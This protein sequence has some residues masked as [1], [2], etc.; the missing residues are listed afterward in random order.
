M[1]EIKV[2]QKIKYGDLIYIE[3]TY[4]KSRTRNILTG[5][6][7]TLK[8]KLD[9]EIKKLDLSK[10]SIYLKDFEDHLFLIFPKM[11]DEFMNNKTFLNDGISLLKT[12]MKT[13]KSLAFDSDFKNNITKV[14]KAFQE[15]K[16]I[17]YSENEKFV[18]FM[19]KQKPIN[20]E[21]DFI[22]IHFKTQSFVKRNENNSIKSSALVLTQTYSEDCIFF[23]S[24][25]SSFNLNMKYVFSNQNVFICKRE[26]NFWSNSHYLIV[27]PISTEKTN[28]NSAKNNNE[29]GKNDYNDKYDKI[30]EK[31]Q[32]YSNFILDFNEGQGQPF[33]IKVCSDYID[34]SSSNLSFAMPVWLV[35]Q[36]A[37]RYLNIKTIVKADNTSTE[38]EPI[39]Q[40][41]EKVSF[42]VNNN[43][44]A[45]VTDGINRI[46]TL[47]SEGK[48]S[49]KARSNNP[50]NN[51]P[52]ILNNNINNINNE[53]QTINNIEHPKR[54]VSMLNSDR[55]LRNLNQQTTFNQPLKKY[56]ITFE[57]VDKEKSINNINGLFYIEQYNEQE[58]Q[59]KSVSDKYIKENFQLKLELKMPSFVEFHKT[60]RFRHITSK[61]YLGIEETNEDIKR[62]LTGNAGEQNLQDNNDKKNDYQGKTKAKLILMDVP[63]DNCNWMLM[64]SYKI[65]ETNDYLLSKDKG[66]K[67]TENSNVAEEKEEEEEEEEK[68]ENEEK[69]NPDE[70]DKIENKSTTSE[71]N[72][73]NDITHKIKIKNNEILRIFHIKTKKFLCF[74]E[75]NNRLGENNRSSQTNPVDDLYT[76]RQDRKVVVPNLTLSRVPY[77]SDLVKLMPSET[78]QSLEISI[79]LYFCHN[80]TEQIDYIMKKDYKKLLGVEAHNIRTTIEPINNNITS[81]NNYIINNNNQFTQENTAK[82]EFNNRTNISLNNINNPGSFNNNNIES[83]NY[84]RTQDYKSK[85]TIATDLKALR[86]KVKE[87]I[88]TYQN[89]IAYCLNNFPVKYDINISPGKPLYYRQQ[90]LFEQGLFKKT[91]KYLEYTK[92][93]SKVFENYTDM[94]KKKFEEEEETEKLR[95]TVNIDIKKTIHKSVKTME[96]E[97]FYDKNNNPN[98]L[99]LDVCKN[100]RTT[101]KLG[102]DFIYSM[103]K[104]NPTNKEY[105]FNHKTLFVHYFLAYEEAAKCFMDLLKENDNFMNLINNHEEKDE[106]KNEEKSEDKNED[107]NED[108]SEDIDKKT[109]EDNIIDTIL[110]YLNEF[111]N[112]EI[113]NLSLLSKFL[114]IGDSGITSNQQYIFEELFFHGKDR[115]LIKIKPIYNDIEF[116]VVYKEDDN[117]QECNLIEFCNNR[118]LVERGMIKYLAEQLN[119]YANL[120]YGRNYVC[121]E[122]IRK[123][124]PLDHLIFHI[125]KVDLN[126]EILAGLINILNYVYIDIEPHIMNVYPTLIKRVSPNLRIERFGKEKIKTYIPLN[127]LSLILCISLFYLNNI[128]YGIVL[129]NT[130]NINMIYNIIKFHLYENVVYSPMDIEEVINNN[131]DQRLHNLKDEVKYNVIN[132]EEYLINKKSEKNIN[133]KDDKR[134]NDLIDE[135]PDLLSANEEEHKLLNEMPT[136]DEENKKGFIG[137]INSFYNKYGFKFLEYNFDAPIGE[138]YVLFV[139]DRIN[140]FFLNS[141]ILSNIDN[142]TEDK[143]IISQN[144][145]SVSSNDILTQSNINYLMTALIEIKKILTN[146]KNELNI[147][148]ISIMKYIEKVINYI[149]DIKTEDMIAYLL[150]NLLK[151]NYQLIDEIIKDKENV[152]NNFEYLYP[153]LKEKLFNLPNIKDILMDNEYYYYQLFNKINFY[154]NIP[155][156][157]MKPENS[158]ENEILNA[159]L[160]KDKAEEQNKR[161]LNNSLISEESSLI[162]FN[163]E[164]FKEIQGL[165]NNYFSSNSNYVNE[166]YHDSEYYYNQEMPFLD[167]N[168]EIFFMNSVI[169]KNLLELIIRILEMNVNAKM[170]KIL[171]RI[172]K[173]LISQRKELFICAKNIL[174]LYRNNDLQKYYL[175]SLT[176][177]ELSLLAEKTEKWMTEDHVPLVIK[178]MDKPENISL[179]EIE[180]DKRDF[181][182]VYSTIYKYLSMIIDFESNSYYNEQEVKLIQ[183]IFY[184]FQMENILS[185]LMKEII[186][187]Y[188]AGENLEEKIEKEKVKTQEI[189]KSQ[190]ASINKNYLVTSL[191]SRRSIR[192]FLEKQKSKK[193]N[194]NSK[195]NKTEK[196]LVYKIALEKLIKIIFKLF[197]ALI[198]NTSPNINPQI[199]ELV[200]F[201]KEYKYLLEFGLLPLIVELSCDD[202]FVHHDIQYLIGL[203]NEQLNVINIKG[204]NEHFN[205]YS[206]YFQKE[207]SKISYSIKDNDNNNTV[208]TSKTFPSKLNFQKLLKKYSLWLKLMKNIIM[209]T[210]EERY[211]NILLEKYVE[212]ITVFD[213]FSLVTP[214][215]LYKNINF[216]PSVLINDSVIAN[217]GR[218]NAFPSKTIR[219]NTLDL[220]SNSTVN[221]DVNC[222]IEYYRLVFIYYMIKIT[223][224]LIK[225]NQQ[226]KQYISGLISIKKLIKFI[227]ELEPPFSRNQ[228]TSLIEAKNYRDSKMFFKLQYYFKVKYIGC[229]LILSISKNSK[230]NRKYMAKNIETYYKRLSEDLKYTFNFSSQIENF[231]KLTQKLANY[232]LVY[233]KYRKCMYKYFFKGLFPLIYYHLSIFNDKLF[234]N[235]NDYQ[236]AKEQ[237]MKINKKWSRLYLEFNNEHDKKPFKSLI[238]YMEHKKKEYQNVFNL[239]NSAS[240]Y[241]ISFAETRTITY[242]KTLKQNFVGPDETKLLT[243]FGDPNRHD[244]ILLEITINTVN[245]LINEI[246]NNEVI[247]KCIRREKKRMARN[248]KTKINFH[249]ILKKFVEKGAQ[250]QTE[251]RLKNE[252]EIHLVNVFLKFIQENADNKKY[253]PIIRELIE[254]M[255]YLVLVTPEIIKREYK[256]EKNNLNYFDQKVLEFKE[257]FFYECQKSY[258]NN[259]AIEIFLKIASQGGKYCHND[260]FNMIIYFYKAILDGGN[261]DVQKKFIQ[262]FQF[263]PNN[264]N[265]FRYISQSFN[266]DVLY[267]LNADPFVEEINI[268]NQNLE[269]VTDKLRFLQ[270]L[271]ENHNQILQNYLREQTNNRISYNFLNILT[272]YLSMLL[273]KLGDLIEKYKKIKRYCIELYYKR[274]LFLLDTI[275]EFLQGPCKNNQEYLI[276]TKVVELFNKIMEETCIITHDDDEEL[277]NNENDEENIFYLSN[278]KANPDSFFSENITNTSRLGLGTEENLYYSD[279]NVQKFKIFSALSDYEKSML[280]FKISLVLLSIIEGRHK[281][282]SVIRKVLRD[283]NYRLVFEKCGEIYKKLRNEMYFFLFIDDNV[284]DIEDLDDKLVAEA[285]FNLYFLMETLVSMENEETELKIN[286]TQIIKAIKRNDK[287][288]KEKLQET[289]TNVDTILKAFEFYSENSL[290][291]E[292]L[293][294]NEIFKVYCPRLQFFNGFDEKMKKDLND[295]ADRTSLQTKLTYLMNKK[296][297]IYMTLKQINILERKYGKFKPLKFLLIYQDKIQLVGLILVI[298]MNIL[299]FIG[300]SAEKDK[301]QINVIQNARIFGL[302]ERTSKA[303]LHFF[304]VII[305]VFDILIFLEF[306]TKDAILIYKNLHRKFLKKSFENK[307]GYIRDFEIHRVYKFLKSS[308]CSLY[309]NKFVIYLKLVINLHVI[310]AISYMIFAILGIFVHHFFFAFHL[311]EFIKSQPILN[312]VFLAFYEPLAE[313]VY[314]YIFFFILIYFYSLLIFYRY[315]DLMPDLSCES[316]LICMMYIYSNTF[317]SGGNLGNFIDTKEESINLSGNMERY[318]LDISYTFIMV[319]LVWQM[320]CGLILDAFDSLRGDREEI[321]EDMETNCYICGLKRDKIEKYYVGKE[322][323]DNHLQ[324]HSVENYLFYM[325]Y[326]EDKDPNEYSGLESYVKENV[327]IESIDWFPRERCLKIEEWENKHKS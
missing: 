182:L 66:I 59:I 117:F 236:R 214:E 242:V 281:K 33:Q 221:T 255:S 189:R 150:E 12:K 167:V 83:L 308:G 42:N 200:I 288:Q 206:S 250:T 265:F 232:F 196:Q 292:I 174:L 152:G 287:M 180:Y 155:K 101:I 98:S 20:Y 46:N 262:L 43:E 160:K 317:T 170:T 25:F 183:K 307:I 209:K 11:K 81:N 303:I 310:Y 67:Y 163:F 80:L 74:D 77:D 56:K 201:S 158:K 130:A 157:F 177:K 88:E 260:T 185:S 271:T 223:N 164:K 58:K 116:K 251:S 16:E 277:Y 118:L 95:S 285:G 286:F 114:I 284:K 215:N 82:K 48:Y 187:E 178:N 29:S 266:K 274:L 44:N 212:I 140:D 313:F 73:K 89:I 124:F 26:K 115:F 133:K 21:D 104:N 314:T 172:F 128:K 169:F 227:F 119:L 240:Q 173:R 121:I 146:E 233:Q 309:C 203:V 261:T 134:N 273:E 210:S 300:Y 283:I 65:L 311:I 217:F 28:T 320:V 207:E 139:L 22:L 17:V 78:N 57:S 49:L 162:E 92:G 247:Q 18:D 94:N 176:I 151:I 27:K 218:R 289:F 321:E 258:L 171:L 263:L 191:N 208:K 96:K 257:H 275:C 229:I 72:E 41:L 13:S 50:I 113:K 322:G 315:Y 45:S 181:F 290:N 68:E 123:I 238:T 294:D 23:F 246:E 295:N 175:C 282:D 137:N 8:G 142:N 225:K 205:D 278:R 244:E 15:T 216:R 91:I 219:S 323:F 190:R 90:F 63:D 154:D 4:R 52:N 93:L 144:F 97:K 268:D 279:D 226:L 86:E 125:S 7:F 107:K 305:L 256:V 186:Q 211:V 64:E 132:G 280:L 299:I 126:Q 267:T 79:V 10:N 14:I 228:I 298:I 243:I 297:Q 245:D 75:V 54:R 199:I 237:Y 254:L 168:F 85:K 259:G 304:G 127:K 272:E 194:K 105:A 202:K 165:T 32:I 30:R 324:D 106:D 31:N 110:K 318:A 213:I 102:F 204:I 241:N 1:E 5:G 122:K 61:K 2:H 149:L 156:F 153:I 195:N 269:M 84:P 301:D 179:N 147:T 24:Q 230:K 327:D 166:A 222:K 60:I 120:C 47:N 235:Y 252:A 55:F 111:K 34:P 248:L 6:E 9:V 87:L 131:L 70:I 312:Y 198:H 306:L 193:Y 184:S 192:S 148:Y 19:K 135:I 129:V 326:L 109:K 62:S 145:K 302:N 38:Y 291:I 293:K 3:F 108:K 231:G 35:V 234:K 103:C 319:W 53:N 100:I 316:P 112:Y 36:S 188:P 159:L 253:F 141:L 161:L 71:T 276:N 239:N 39:N 325:L 296:E 224:N 270:L 37:D 136:K 220:K 138:E 264:D 76:A 249:S 99:I 51:I 40:N 143:N 197:I 69:D